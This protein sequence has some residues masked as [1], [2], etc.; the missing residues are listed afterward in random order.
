M[1]GSEFRGV[2]TIEIINMLFK[3]NTEKSIDRHASKLWRS[4]FMKFT[5]KADF[6]VAKHVVETSFCEILRRKTKMKK[7][8]KAQ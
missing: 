2:S 4:I 8:P 1:I 5:S 6:V 7:V 3:I